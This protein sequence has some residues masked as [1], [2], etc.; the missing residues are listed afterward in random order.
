MGNIC[1]NLWA[2]D[3]VFLFMN[4]QNNTDSWTPFCINNFAYR[5]SFEPDGYASHNHRDILCSEQE[6]EICPYTILSKHKTHEYYY[7]VR[8]EAELHRKR[9]DGFEN[10]CCIL[11]ATDL[12]LPSACLLLLLSSPNIIVQRIADCHH[13]I[14]QVATNEMVYV[15]EMFVEMQRHI[16]ATKT[17]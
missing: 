9:F 16:R 8:R 11:L 15:R 5:G 10:V 14:P 6:N 17:K 4:N 13:I 7:Y 3:V 1:K 12:W 2:S